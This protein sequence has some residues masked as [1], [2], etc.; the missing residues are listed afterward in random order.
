MRAAWLLLPLLLLAAERSDAAR[1]A[2]KLKP[3]FVKDTAWENNPA[4]SVSF[5]CSTADPTQLLR[6]HHFNQAQVGVN[7]TGFILHRAGSRQALIE[8]GTNDGRNIKKL[9]ETG[10]FRLVSSIEFSPVYFSRV[11]A[12]LGGT[13]GLRLY[14][15]DSGVVLPRAL[16]D[17]ASVVPGGVVVW[18]DAH[19]S[20]GKTAGAT[21]KEPPI[22]KEATA[23][24]TSEFARDHVL[25]MDDVR[26]FG[27]YLYR[28]NYPTPTQVQQH[29]CRM[30]PQAYF[31]YENDALTIWS[32]NPSRR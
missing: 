30:Q 22:L 2:G 7:K 11:N 17:T 9:H 4:T 25:I 29:V 28:Q 31:C 13:P 12:T 19:Y 10:V 18:L 27:A 5:D 16:A 26:L 24:L 32:G 3:V 14:S 15:G 21:Q 8:T 20:L 23:V 6:M 1:L